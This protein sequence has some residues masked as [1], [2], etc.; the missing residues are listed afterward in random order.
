[1]GREGIPQTIAATLPTNDCTRLRVAFAG[2]GFP[3]CLS[4][5]VSLSSVYGEGVELG[6]RHWLNANQMNKRFVIDQY[7]IP[8]I[9]VFR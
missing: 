6:A 9:V 7:A 5:S 4:L 3:V 2:D 8:G 1:M